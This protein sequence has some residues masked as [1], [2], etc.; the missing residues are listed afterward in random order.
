VRAGSPEPG[1]RLPHT[2]ALIFGLLCLVALLGLWLPEGS[3]ARDAGGRV[4]PGSFVSH[5]GAP[6]GPRGWALILALLTAP[7]RGLVASAE[8]V[9]FLLAVGGAFR[10]VE[11]SGALEAA[12]RGAVR[13]LRG[14]ESLF[15]PALMLLFSASG[16]VFG[17]SEEVI[18]FV[19]V[20]A[21]VIRGLGYAPIIAVAVPL[22]GAGMGFAGAMLNPFTVGLAQA[23]AG[24]PPMSGWG[25]RTVVWA[26]L[27]ALGVLFTIRLARRSRRP[28]SPAEPLTAD[29]PAPASP[30]SPRRQAAVLALFIGS[31]A[32][33]GAGIWL[34]S[35][36]VVEIAGIFV[37]LGIAA[38]LAA[39]MSSH[40]IGEALTE[41]AA[42]LLPAVLVVAAARGAVELAGQLRALDP[43]LAAA[44]AAME[45][46]A[47][48]TSLL[49][50]FA[51]QSGL[52]VLVPSGSGQAALTMPI[53]APL[54]DLLGV[55]RQ[56]AVLAFQLG[57]GFTN[58]ITPTSAVLMGSLH[59]GGVTYGE[60]LRSTWT[61]QLWLAL[62]GA[63][64]LA[65][66]LWW[67]F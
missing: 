46:S 40:T 36:Y 63:L 25:Y 7:V 4:I 24:L 34:W 59:A 9:G 1:P 44:A 35:W 16:A 52:N 22:I 18:P 66:G 10:V 38:G 26:G 49:G 33:V 64:A 45:G 20:L 42:S 43:L 53:M 23:I 12:I 62:A 37:G 67:G 6:A 19:L 8:I 57:D 56:L 48:Y 65:G 5:E 51:F 29:D 15:I 3:F 2:L 58:L 55:S 61:L 27:T 21:P 47:A 50:M 30:V 54:A 13:R 39:R 32:L 28:S 60:W 31:I 17:M 41:G 14:R 11:R